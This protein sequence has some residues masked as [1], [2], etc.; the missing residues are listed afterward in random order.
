MKYGQVIKLKNEGSIN[1][2]QFDYIVLPPQVSQYGDEDGSAS[3]AGTEPDYW[4]IDPYEKD[5][6]LAN[7]EANM[8]AIHRLFMT[9]HSLVNRKDFLHGYTA[10]HWAAKHGRCDIITA[11]AINGGMVNLKSVSMHGD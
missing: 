6:M 10:M 3:I 2:N 1:S 7:A 9:E 4:D 11:L 5:W 8:E